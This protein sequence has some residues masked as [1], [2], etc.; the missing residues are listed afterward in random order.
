MNYYMEDDG[1]QEIILRALRPNQFQRVVDS[2]GETKVFMVFM[3]ETN[4]SAVVIEGD[5]QRDE[6]QGPSEDRKCS[7]I[8]LWSEKN[9]VVVN[10]YGTGKECRFD[11]MPL[12]DNPQSINVLGEIPAVFTQEGDVQDRPALNN[13]A[14]QTVTANVMMSTILSGMSAQSFGQLVVKYPEGQTMPDV[15]QQGMFTFLKLPQAGEGQPETTADY[16]SPKPDLSSSL[17]VFRGY[18]AAMLDEHQ[19]NAGVIAGNV[20]KFTSG[21]DRLL[22][23]SDT[24]EVIEGNQ[25][26]YAKCEKGIYELIKAFYAAKSEF[27]F[28]SES[29]MV[30]YIKPSPSMS[31]KEILENEK[32][33]LDMGIIQ[34]HEVLIALDPNTDEQDAIDRIAEIDSNKKDN[35]SQFSDAL[36]GRKDKT[37]IGAKVAVDA[38]RQKEIEDNE[39]VKAL[40]K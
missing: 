7:T 20:E 40:I 8:A 22:S 33:K 18:I 9:H 15:L 24:N 14:S 21:L 23:Q 36:N 30:K 12:V 34:K 27:N 28:T 29:L 35:M 39:K 5:G 38:M 31:E 16:I 1:S 13:L 32:V 25:E 26:A 17:E 37:V 4:S 11:V 3:G 6:F 10:V 2:K 19:I